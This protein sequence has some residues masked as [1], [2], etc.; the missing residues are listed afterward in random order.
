[1]AGE[2]TAGPSEAGRAALRDAEWAGARACFEPPLAAD[3]AE[4]DRIAGTLGD[5]LTEA[6]DRLS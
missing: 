5:V 3:Q 4:F 1:M 6:W 2:R